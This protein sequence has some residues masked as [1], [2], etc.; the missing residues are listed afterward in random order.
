MSSS[1][2]ES[3]EDGRLAVQAGTDALNLAAMAT[4][5]TATTG[6]T[7]TTSRK[8]GL[9]SPGGPSRR[10]PALAHEV[11]LALIRAKRAELSSPQ[12]STTRMLSG[13]ARWA[14][15]VDVMAAAGHPG[16]DSEK[17][18]KKWN[19]LVQTYRK[20]KEYEKLPGVKSYW[21]LT[22]A[23]KKEKGIEVYIN[24]PTFMA[25]AEFMA[26]RD[27][28]NLHANNNGG[29]AANSNPIRDLACV[30]STRSNGAGG[31]VMHDV[32]E[33]GGEDGEGEGEGGGVSH[34]NVPGTPSRGAPGN[35]TD[36]AVNSG[37]KSRTQ[38]MAASVE[39][40]THAYVHGSEQFIAAMRDGSVTMGNSMDLQTVAMRDSAREVAA[41]IRDSGR[42]LAASL[43]GLAA[44]LAASRQANYHPLPHPPPPP[45]HHHHQPAPPPPPPQFNTTP[46]Y[47]GAPQHHTV[48]RTQIFQ[49][50]NE[51]V[52]N[53]HVP[54]EWQTPSQAL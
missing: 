47:G 17:L 38:S 49:S 29:M 32:E 3:E 16:M 53:P 27:A 18:R 48:R 25:M 1:S 30:P 45:A 50:G 39:G 36:G 35:D 37:K 12:G 19:N 2:G 22:P 21:D 26:E 46:E 23:E 15:I 4:A 14:A 41:A 43:A 9:A 7:T 54:T 31:G 52:C 8:R 51:G 40:L 5:T 13:S 20:V 44:S 6:T 33:D 34:G 10:A 28:M 42:E 11:V 24:Q